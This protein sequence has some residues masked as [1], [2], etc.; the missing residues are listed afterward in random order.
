MLN[1]RGKQLCRM[2]D[3]IL[4][5]FPFDPDQSD[6]SVS[7]VNALLAP[8]TGALWKFYDGGL[9]PLLPL[10]NGTYS[11]RPINGVTL[12]PQFVTFFRWMARASGALYMD[13]GAT[14]RMSLSIKAL[15]T[16]DAS[17][18]VTLFH[19]DRTPRLVPGA[20]A[21]SVSWPPSGGSSARLTVS[22]GGREQEIARADGPWALFRVMARA[23]SNEGS[24]RTRVL[25]F[26][27]AAPVALELTAPGVGPVVQ[28]GAL[29]GPACV[30][31]VVQ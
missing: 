14:P 26:S 20:E 18:T 31:P 5:K 9:Q 21:Q 12:S 23:T 8:G 3:R 15:P 30:S 10:L 4:K 19:G 29:T 16:G 7:D 27:G 11:S 22:N 13:K 6:A 2:M 28:R 25:T 1:D 17:G 24:G